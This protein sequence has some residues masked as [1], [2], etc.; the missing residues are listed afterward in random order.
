MPIP[1]RTH[2]SP[3]VYLRG[4][5]CSGEKIWQTDKSTN[6]AICTGVKNVAVIAHLYT[7]F[8][9]NRL[10]IFEAWYPELISHLTAKRPL[11]VE[12]RGYL[13][14]LLGIMRARVPAQLNQWEERLKQF[15]GHLPLPRNANMIGMLIEA[16]VAARVLRPSNFLIVTVKDGEPRLITSDNPAGRLFF[17]LT[18]SMLLMSLSES[19]KIGSEYAI[20]DGRYVK[21]VNK[22][23]FDT[24]QNYIFSNS[25][26]FAIGEKNILDDITGEK[27]LPAEYL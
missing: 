8:V 19:K 13:S 7:P 20:A 25:V 24:A 18:D 11:N 9:E 12:I 22:I 23:T 27:G 3:E 21:M 1:K 5:S 15:E 26:P 4:F 17:P 14:A 2:Y 6:A 10:A 16:E